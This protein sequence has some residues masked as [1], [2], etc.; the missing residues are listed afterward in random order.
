MRI[1]P[2]R[3]ATR[4]L[5][6]AAGGAVLA[7]GC[8]PAR[9]RL[10][11]E[12]ERA[13][14]SFFAAAPRPS[15]PFEASFSGVAELTGRAVPFV[16]G[17]KSAAPSDETVGIYDPLGRPVL[18][19]A[20]DG[21][22]LR[23][24]RGEA[25][26]ELLRGMELPIPADGAGIP[27]GPLSLA[28]VLSGAP[29]YP[30]AKGEADRTAD[31]AWVFAD[32]RQELFSDPSRKRISRAEYRIAGK[33]IAVTYPGRDDAGPPCA[34]AIEGSGVKIVLRRDEE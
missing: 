13:A 11:G 10:A 18:S 7:A 6:L 31:G 28:G 4:A 26:G 23:L 20:N 1:L 32:G 30:V 12:E 17:I 14:V 34:V 25:A 24:A 16:A 5:L 19:L 2:G 22:R 3:L 33:R 15:F 29:G 8:A 21:V 9:Y 27:A